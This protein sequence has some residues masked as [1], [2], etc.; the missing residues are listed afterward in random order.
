VIS[1]AQKSQGTL[2][3]ALQ[4]TKT[5]NGKGEP[6]LTN[7]QYQA[8]QNFP[9]AVQQGMVD[10]IQKNWKNEKPEEETKI[11]NIG[12]YDVKTGPGTVIKQPQPKSNYSPVSSSKMAKSLKEQIDSEEFADLPEEEQNLIWDEYKAHVQNSRFKAGGATPAAPAAPAAAAPT[13]SKSRLD[14]LLK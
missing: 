8:M 13:G 11:E 5:F 4:M 7:E 14:A 6:M 9:P 2:G 12:G 3:A 1:D 10:V